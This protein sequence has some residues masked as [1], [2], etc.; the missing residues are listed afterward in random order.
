M[1]DQ[2]SKLTRKIYDRVDDLHALIFAI[3]IW[4][5]LKGAKHG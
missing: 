4:I 3:A 5:T 2:L 1:T